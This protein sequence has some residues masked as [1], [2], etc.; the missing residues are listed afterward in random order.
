[1]FSRMVAETKEHSP[2]NNINRPVQIVRVFDSFRVFETL[3]IYSE[4]A[5]RILASKLRVAHFAGGVVELEIVKPKETSN[6][7]IY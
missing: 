3:F 4:R 7:R 6:V 5:K 2:C 1:M